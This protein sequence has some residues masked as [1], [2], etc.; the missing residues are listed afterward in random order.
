MV[1]MVALDR[2]QGMLESVLGY[3]PPKAIELALDENFSKIEALY[4]DRI[5]SIH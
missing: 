4:G 5:F 1:Q 2:I 3:S